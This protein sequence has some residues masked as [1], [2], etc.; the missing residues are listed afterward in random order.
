MTSTLVKGRSRGVGTAIF[1]L[2]SLLSLVWP[3]G[4]IADNYGGDRGPGNTQAVL[5][6][7]AFGTILVYL[8]QRFRWGGRG[9]SSAGGAA[10]LEIISGCLVGLAAIHIGWWTGDAKSPG[11][12]FTIA[13]IATAARAIWVN[14]ERLTWAERG[15]SVASDI[16]LAVASGMQLGEAG[17]SDLGFYNRHA[18]PGPA[19]GTMLWF[20][21]ATIFPLVLAVALGILSRSRRPRVTVQP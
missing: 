4:G 12:L 3:W 11:L 20:F 7:W 19:V 6:I 9:G 14:S 21:F 18:V 16:I 10:P 13:G 1:V 2:F 15:L 17:Y 5:V 8:S